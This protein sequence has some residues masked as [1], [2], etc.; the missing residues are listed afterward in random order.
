QSIQQPDA[1]PEAGDGAERATP[2]AKETRAARTTERDWQTFLRAIAE[3]AYHNKRHR[4]GDLYR[5]LN[6]DVLRQCFYR[7][8]KDAASGVDRVT[9][10]EYERNL[11]A[12]LSDLEGR[13]HRN[14]CR[15]RRV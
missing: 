13:L 7:L 1:S 6:R 4:F 15:A 5:W 11:E 2:P 9:F 8:R 14:A 12:N 10:Q 3:K